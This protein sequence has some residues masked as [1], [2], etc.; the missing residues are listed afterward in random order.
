[1]SRGR[2]RRHRQIRLRTWSRVIAI[3]AAGVLAL[4]AC[5]DSEPTDH[6][7]STGPLDLPIEMVVIGDFGDGGQ[8]EYA[9][10]NEVRDTVESRDVSVF[11]T[12]GDNFYSDDVEAVWDRPYGWLDE[13]GVTVLAA[14]GNHDIETETRVGLVQEALDPPGRWYA[15]DLGPGDLIV[16]DSNLVGD[17]S[18]TEWL[19][20]ELEGSDPPTIVVFHHPAFSCGVHGTDDKIQ[21]NWV[22][23]FEEHEVTVV[24]NGHDH[25]YERFVIDDT[26]Y[27][28][29]GGGGRRL[30][31]ANACPAGT[32]E[33][34]ARDYETHHF[35][36]ME[37]S[38]TLL[39]AQV[40]AADGT[41]IDA[42]DIDY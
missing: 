40:I 19:E 22:P 33:P 34:V 7:G 42:F 23:L 9:V 39:S 10:A 32:P 12:T 26:T 38:D 3:L 18:Q 11:L 31:P 16:L 27:V 25:N 21:A 6:A 13:E 35:I 17:S 1:M 15:V 36:V 20:D 37:I 41:S 14:W 28:V 30:T 2:P 29:T 5:Q 8:S 4:G 24:F